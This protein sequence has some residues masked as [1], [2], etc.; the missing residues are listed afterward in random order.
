[1]L[2]SFKIALAIGVALL[3]S[4]FAPADAKAGWGHWGHHHGWGGG[5]GGGWGYG[6]WGHHHG[7]YGGGLA[8][9]YGLPYYGGSWGG[10]GWPSYGWGSSYTSLSIGLGPAWWGG[11]S[12][13]Y[14]RRYPYI[15]PGSLSPYDTFYYPG[16][17]SYPVSSYA[18]RPYYASGYGTYGSSIYGS[19]SCCAPVVASTCCDPCA[20]LPVDSSVP[21]TAAPTYNAPEAAPAPPAEPAPASAEA[22]P[23]VRALPNWIPSSSLTRAEQERGVANGSLLTAAGRGSVQSV[24]LA[25]PVMPE[26]ATDLVPL[27]TTLLQAADAIFAAGDY[28]QAAAAYARLTIRYGNHDE[29]AVRRFIA[30]V[31]SGDCEQA[32]VMFEA[33]SLSEQSLLASALPSGGLAELYG[34]SA[35]QRETHADYL[36]AYA[37]RHPDDGLALAMVGTWLELDGQNERAQLFMQ[38]AAALTPGQQEQESRQ[39]EPSDKQPSDQLPVNSAH[40]V[41]TDISQ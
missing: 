37:L 32:A 17:A 39:Q 40:L 28:R 25:K 13:D 33:A 6:G 9:V 2:R 8:S 15:Y 23:S 19:S 31:A 34:A 10:Y 27:S 5:Y 11:Y 14:P 21:S 7:Y 1:M 12:Y 16:I 35:S 26:I 41:A 3:G 4:L 38:R 30:L 22:A 36:A 29:L 20:G 18:Y 24:S